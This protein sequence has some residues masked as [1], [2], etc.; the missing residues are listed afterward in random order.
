MFKNCKL[1]NITDESQQLCPVDQS[2][3]GM[4]RSLLSRHYPK[5]LIQISVQPTLEQE[6]MIRY[7]IM[8]HHSISSK[9]FRSF[10]TLNL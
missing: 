7:Q 8:H 2:L 6:G 9:D 4:A 5:S 10:N 1:E 3:R